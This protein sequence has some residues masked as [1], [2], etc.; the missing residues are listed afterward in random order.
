MEQVKRLPLAI[1]VQPGFS[2]LDKRYLKSYEQYLLPEKIA[3]QVPLRELYEAGVCLCGSSDSPVQSIDPFAQ[4]LGMTEFYLPDQALT[5]YQALRT[6]TVN[7][8]QMLGEETEW[9][10][11]EEGKRADFMVLKKDFLAAEGAE[12]GAFC[13]EYTVKDG[14]RLTPKRGTAAELAGLCLKRPKK[15]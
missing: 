3:Q 7:P 8:A 4:M 5:P 12:A 13:A 14:R 10:T 15:L 11:L 6:Y 9:G 2:W 1:T